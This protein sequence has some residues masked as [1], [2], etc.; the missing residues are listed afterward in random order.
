MLMMHKAMACGLP[1]VATGEPRYELYGFGAAAFLLA[2][3][4][5]THPVEGLR[6]NRF[7]SRST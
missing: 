4:D 5:A 2:P 7:P 3:H 1:V 6:A